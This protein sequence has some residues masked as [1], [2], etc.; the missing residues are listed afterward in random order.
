M[1][2][3]NT[4]GLI[5]ILDSTIRL[6]KGELLDSDAE[7]AAAL[8]R[9][10]ESKRLFGTD[11]LMFAEGD[12]FS[13]QDFRSKKD[14]ELVSG[15]YNYAQDITHRLMT[16]RGTM[17][18]DPF[19]GVP[20]NEYL[21]TTYANPS[22]LIRSLIAEVTE[23]LYK[24]NRTSRVEY[25]NPEFEAPNVLKVECAVTPVKYSLSLFSSLTLGV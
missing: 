23:E 7:Q 11:L 24:D 19:F 1:A 22:N 13:E 6:N 9:N 5:R 4:G 10:S 16:T 15:V 14:L 20:W 2:Y 25:V 18:G 3:N 17:P 12:L 21:G 8:S